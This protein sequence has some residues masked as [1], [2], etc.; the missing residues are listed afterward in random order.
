MPVCLCVILNVIYPF[1]IISVSV[2]AMLQCNEL[3]R[4]T[5]CLS[6]NHKTSAEEKNQSSF[7]WEQLQMRVKS[8]WELIRKVMPKWIATLQGKLILSEYCGPKILKKRLKKEKFL[9][10]KCGPRMLQTNSM[11]ICL[12]N[13][14]YVYCKSV[15]WKLWR[16]NVL[17][18]TI[19][20]EW[21]PGI[22][23]MT[24]STHKYIYHWRPGISKRQWHY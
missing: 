24:E 21:Q 5:Q 4:V 1:L 6:A 16:R 15:P 10:T 3:I 9:W 2:Y 17:N 13:G 11:Q 14:K 22:S 19:F 20:N 23:R 8:D 12:V 18:T 7:I